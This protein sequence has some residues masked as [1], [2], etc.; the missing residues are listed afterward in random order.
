MSDPISLLALGAAIGGATG[1][2]VEK[3]WDSGERWITNYYQDHRPN[4][5]TTA[6]SN[7]SEFLAD[8]A[9]RIGNLEKMTPGA[10]EKIEISQDQPDFSVLLQKAIIGA[11]QTNDKNKHQ[12]LA[13]IIA[14]RLIS[15]SETMIS[16]TSKIA[17]D[18]IPN[19]TP[20]QIKLLGLISEIYSV[21][22]SEKLS[23]PQFA[24]WF[25][26]RINPY[27][28]LKYT[29]LDLLHLE[30]LSCLKNNQFLSRD[31]IEIMKNKNQEPFNVENINHDLWQKIS[32]DFNEGLKSVDLTSVGQL[33]GVYATD[34]LTGSNTTFNGWE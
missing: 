8:L 29:T 14:N 28:D 4:A 25:S 10:K 7:S 23:P 27:A 12:L 13:S 34:L 16:L 21:K 22:P 24:S 19:L 30:S 11:A 9:Q 1:K 5:L 2:F 33:I 6:H 15:S 20:N 26:T 3:A 17:V 18:V 32:K 31:L